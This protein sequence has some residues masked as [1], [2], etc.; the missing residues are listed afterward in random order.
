MV[1]VDWEITGGTALQK[2]ERYTLKGTL[3]FPPGERYR[4]FRLP[5]VDDAIANGDR[6]LVVSLS[7]PRNAV[8]G[9]HRNY[10]YTILD[11][12]RQ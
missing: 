11:N 3:Y 6:S 2:N 5:I 12:D 1:L 4:H 10:T 9:K 8:L 7:N